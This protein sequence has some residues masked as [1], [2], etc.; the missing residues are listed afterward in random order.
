MKKNSNVV[1]IKEFQVND[2][3]FKIGHEMKY[4]TRLRTGVN[5]LADSNAKGYLECSDET[6]KNFKEVVEED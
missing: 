4:I 5:I 6:L 2:K 1:V 3:I